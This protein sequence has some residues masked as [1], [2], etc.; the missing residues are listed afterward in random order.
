MQVLYEDN[1]LLVVVKE[2]NLPVQAD[3]SGDDDLLSRAKRYIKEK[4]KKP[5]EVYLGLV[6]RLDRPAGGVMVFA[7]TSKA[8]ARL[9]EQ[10][11]SHATQKK[12][13]A[14]TLGKAKPRARLDD[15]IAR[16]EALGALASRV[17]GAG[18]KLVEETAPGA[19]SA[20]LFYTLAAQKEGVSLLDVSL[21]TGRHHQ[22]RAQLAGHS[23]PLLGDQ[24]YNREA[25]A[26]EQL[27]L[28]AYSLTL[29]HPTLHTCL[30][31]TA[32]PEGGAWTPFSRELCAM[33]K[34]L[35]LAY[36]DENLLA[37]VKPAGVETCAQDA[38]G[39]DSLETRLCEALTQKLYPVHRLDA[40]T[41]GLVLFAKSENAQTALTDA[42]RAHQLH[43]LYRCTIKGVPSPER[44]TLCAYLKKDAEAARVSISDTESPGAKKIQ[45]A[46]RVLKQKSRT[47]GG[48]ELEI[49][50]LSGR[51]HQIRAHMAYLLH[52]LLGDD[53]YGDRAWNKA[54]K[55]TELHLCS[56]R[57]TFE[58][59][60]DSIL[61]YLNGIEISTTPFWDE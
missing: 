33:A 59:P 4:Y 57:I 1:H 42:I 15:F 36:E 46:Y 14:L 22:I 11:K 55:C 51:T 18:A 32:L 20:S 26:G 48:A 27:A 2:P 47:I 13:A 58:I 60:I 24:R 35:Y 54:C 17:R 50:L 61:N 10:F 16:E 43:K 29:E 38:K 41:T 23:L 56:A 19:K 6:H 30:C 45:T 25:R 3:A 12:Y 34:G 40:A 21:Y 39:E 49:E 28:W 8:A 5:G 44:A 7:R 53:K 52:P 9:S 37:I 31:F